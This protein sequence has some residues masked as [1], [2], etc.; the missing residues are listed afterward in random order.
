MMV[1][2]QRGFTLI[3]ALVALLV[4]SIGMLGVAAMQLNALKSAHMGYQRSVVSLAAVDAQERVWGYLAGNENWC[5][6][7]K[8]S[9]EDA[10]ST[11]EGEWKSTWFGEGKVLKGNG[12]KLRDKDAGGNSLADCEYEVSIRGGKGDFVYRFRLPV[13]SG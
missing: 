6:G 11:I 7:L 2:R 12:I 8:P 4:L 5:P 3:E 13:L 9:Y 1:G 10:L